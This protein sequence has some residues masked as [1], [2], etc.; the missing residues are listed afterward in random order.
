MPTLRASTIL[1][2]VALIGCKPAD[3]PEDQPPAPVGPEDAAESFARQI[4][5][6]LYACEEC[7]AQA[8]NF[9]G[10]D[11]C[12]EELRAE[13]QQ[14]I[15]EALGAGGTWDADCAGELVR[16]WAIWDCLGPVSA[17]RQASYDR[18]LCPVV[19]GSVAAGDDCVVSSIGDNCNEGSVCVSGVCVQTEV[20]IPLGQVCEFDWQELPCVSGTYCAYDGETRRCQPLPSE[21]DDCDA[22]YTCGPTSRNL[23]CNYDSLTCEL[24][25]GV[26][27]PCFQG[28]SCGP[29]LYC[30]GGKDFTCQE[31]FELGDGCAADAVCPV[32][33][34][35]IGNICTA[36]PPA[37]CSLYYFGI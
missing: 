17:N 19:K 3:P 30:D 14:S 5:A 26:G 20:P 2:S 1:L 23:L 9:A 36:D 33:A 31:R 21:G 34:S 11:A 10:E 32:D 28:S 15:D 7:S 4:C 16:A 37:V 35:C 8:G 24:G 29:G 6:S 25:P 12:I 27:E 22:G 18:R 13:F